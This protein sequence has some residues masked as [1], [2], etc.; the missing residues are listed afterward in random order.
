[1]ECHDLADA[2]GDRRTSWNVRTWLGI[3]LEMQGALD[4]AARGQCRSD[5]SGVGRKPSPPISF[6]TDDRGNGP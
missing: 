3:A 1:M 2:L 4:E 6:D 5:Q